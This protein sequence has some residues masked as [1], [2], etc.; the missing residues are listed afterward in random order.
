[1]GLGFGRVGLRLRASARV[2]AGLT[3]NTSG[4]AESSGPPGEG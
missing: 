1:M 4:A 3:S 2:S